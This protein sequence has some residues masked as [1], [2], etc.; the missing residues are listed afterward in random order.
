[1]ANA[2]HRPRGQDEH[3]SKTY[4]VSDTGIGSCFKQLTDSFHMPVVAGIMKSGP[5]ILQ[6]STR[7]P[8]RLRPSQQNHNRFYTIYLQPYIVSSVNISSCLQQ[9]PDGSKVSIVTG[10]LKGGPTIL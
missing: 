4:V 9:L 1:M 5:T 6:Y 3:S 7:K 10:I 2:S 8:V